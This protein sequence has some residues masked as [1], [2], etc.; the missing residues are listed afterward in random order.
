MV[1]CLHV[2]DFTVLIAIGLQS[3]R[4]QLNAADILIEGFSP[5]HW[6][7]L[8]RVDLS[9]MPILFPVDT[10]LNV[11]RTVQAVLFLPSY[12]AA[13]ATPRH[14]TRVTPLQDSVISLTVMF[15]GNMKGIN[16]RGQIMWWWCHFKIRGHAKLSQSGLCQIDRRGGNNSSLLWLCFFYPSAECMSTECPVTSLL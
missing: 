3:S 5:V 2:G 4:A 15:P 10:F 7:Q 8:G 11:P 16:S 14:T 1:W 12:S 6:A 9:Q 13:R